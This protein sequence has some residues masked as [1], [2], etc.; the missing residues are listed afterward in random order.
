MSQQVSEAKFEKILSKIRKLLDLADHANTPPHEAESARASAE[1]LMAEYRVS[2]EQTLA[3]DPESMK[4]E[5]VNIDIA[6]CHSKFYMQYLNLFH[7]IARHN[8]IQAKYVWSGPTLVAQAVGYAADLKLTDLMYT[9]ARLVFAERIEPSVKKELSDAENIYRLRSA[10]I[11]RNRVAALLWGSASDDGA[12][13]GKVAKVY[14]AECEKRG[15]K[16]ALNGRQ[17]NA[18]TYR[19]VYANSFTDEIYRRLRRAREG[20]DRMGGLPALHGREE[21][22]QEAFWTFFPDQR[23][24]TEV[25]KSTSCATCKKARKAGRDGCRK[26]NPAWTKAD[27]ARSERLNYSAAARAG[28]RAGVDAA[29]EVALDGRPSEQRLDRYAETERAD[30]REIWAAIGGSE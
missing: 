1:R 6:T 15:E 22:V 11:P 24:S 23:P 2:E 5:L 12:A 7:S 27:Q 14:K 18:K 30:T 26:C 17:V 4:P 20:A 13:H 10:G 25:A 28:Q 29:A 21:R 16:P 8:G 19:E 9:A 3:A